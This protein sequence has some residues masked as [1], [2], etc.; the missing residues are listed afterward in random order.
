MQQQ[1]NNDWSPFPIVNN[2]RTK[3]SQELLDQKQHTKTKDDL[4]DVP[5]ALL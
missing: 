3:P 1:Q 2:Q 5:E 4:S